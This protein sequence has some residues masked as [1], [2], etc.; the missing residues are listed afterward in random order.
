MVYV[1]WDSSALVLKVNPRAFCLN[2]INRIKSNQPKVESKQA[3]NFCEKV[4]ESENQEDGE[5]ST[6][7]VEGRLEGFLSPGSVGESSLSGMMAEEEAAG[8]FLCLSELAS[9]YPNIWLL[10]LC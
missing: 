5:R 2:I 9:F 1:P 3:T 6:Q 7:E 4:I 10:S 8:C